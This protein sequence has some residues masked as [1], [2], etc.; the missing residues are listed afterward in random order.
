MLFLVDCLL[1]PSL[2]DRDIIGLKLGGVSGLK[3]AS[4]FSLTAS[5]LARENE[6]LAAA[7]ASRSLEIL[8]WKILT[9]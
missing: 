7:S 4:M 1:F 9:V 8:D 6:V 5:G 3:F 2:G